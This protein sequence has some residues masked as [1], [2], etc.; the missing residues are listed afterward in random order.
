MNSVGSWK[1]QE[2]L[3]A[4]YKCYNTIVDILVYDVVLCR[5]PSQSCH[6]E[7]HHDSQVNA[8]QVYKGKQAGCVRHARDTLPPNDKCFWSIYQNGMLTGASS[9]LLPTHTPFV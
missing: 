9:W 2:A 8:D 4:C 7:H 6:D 1:P 3:L 5:S